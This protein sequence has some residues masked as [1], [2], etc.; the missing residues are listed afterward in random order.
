MTAKGARARWS[1]V[2]A[3]LGAMDQKELLS[4][5]RD[6][7]EADSVNRRFLHARYLPSQ[8]TIEEYRHHVADAVYPDAFS[9]RGIRL[10][11]ANA[12]ITEYRRSTGDVAGSVDLML[13][14]VEAG[15]DHA[16]DLGA[17]DDSYFA[18]LE[19]KVDGIV[20]SLDALSADQRA[21]ATAR[22]VRIRDRAE[23]NIGWGYA[24]WLD[25]VVTD[26]V[27]RDIR[28]Q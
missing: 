10:R 12:A 8:T 22:L 9:R 14:F 16:L 18:A 6:L 21:A 25:D 19:H 5:I 2:K 1:E 7:Y 17:G 3:I 15:T 28:S 20:R 23:G 11:E 13:T 24:D 26:L 27:G 4:V